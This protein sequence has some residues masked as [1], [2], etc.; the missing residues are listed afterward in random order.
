MSV[1]FPR[2]PSD[3]RHATP[4]TTAPASPSWP[5]IWN[6]DP[7]MWHTAMETGREMGETSARL[8]A[9]E[10]DLTELKSLITALTARVKALEDWS[11]WAVLKT[12][13]WAR[14]GLGAVI[15]AQWWRR[16]LSEAD[17]LRAISKL[18]GGS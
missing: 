13:P 16:H 5:P 11:L 1:R 15:L 18:F 4:S 6:P 17:A 12:W 7:N 3:H 14:I 10:D 8:T 2:P 9:Q